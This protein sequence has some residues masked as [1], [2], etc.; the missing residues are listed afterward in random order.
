MKIVQLDAGHGGHDS[1]A[2]GNGLKEKDIALSVTLK[3][4]EILKRHKV[5]VVYS[6]TKDEFIRLSERATMANEAKADLFLSVHCNAYEDSSAQGVE[7]FSYPTS[8]RGED[9]ST[10]ILDSIVKDKVYTKNRGIKTAKFA[11]LRLTK[12]PSTLVELGFITNPEDA[13]ILKNRQDELAQSVAKGVLKFLGIDFIEDTTGENYNYIQAVH[14]LAA[15]DI[16]N[17]PELWLDSEEFTNN[18]V[19][20]L[21]IKFAAYVR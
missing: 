1:G 13:Q 16:I 17:S 18:N 10:F 20:S 7:V 4:G 8:T 12:M 3:I 19:K 15:L 9:L 14:E 2:T 21:V 6:R 11:V 5:K